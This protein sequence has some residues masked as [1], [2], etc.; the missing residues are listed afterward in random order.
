MCQARCRFETRQ[1]LLLPRLLLQ[2]LDLRDQLVVF[3]ELALQ[4]AFGQPGAGLEARRG[5]D[6]DI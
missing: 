5:Q 1:G 6:V 4:K 2:A 3:A